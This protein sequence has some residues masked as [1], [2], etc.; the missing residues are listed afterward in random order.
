MS[1][2]DVFL[3]VL[4]FSCACSFFMGL[5]QKVGSLR[6]GEEQPTLEVSALGSLAGILGVGYFVAW[7]VVSHQPP[8]K[9]IPVFIIAVLAYRFG[10][11]FACR[12]LR[13]WLPL[14]GVCGVPFSFHFSSFLGLI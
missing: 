7:L 3:L 13:I 10:A 11:S 5:G 4:F 9:L 1:E 8:L 12:S 6:G 14:V 2:L